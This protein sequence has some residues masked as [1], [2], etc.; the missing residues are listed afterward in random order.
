MSLR[1]EINVL[2]IFL[3]FLASDVIVQNLVPILDILNRFKAYRFK[4]SSPDFLFNCC[5]QLVNKSMEDTTPKT[6]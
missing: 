3:Y 2:N 6:F 1:L 4:Y 5:Y